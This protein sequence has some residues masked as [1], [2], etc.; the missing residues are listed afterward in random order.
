[1][2]YTIFTCHLESKHYIGNECLIISGDDET[3]C[4]E[5]L[6]TEI[7]KWYDYYEIEQY[8][9][10]IP[11]ENLKEIDDDIRTKIIDEIKENSYYNITDQDLLE[12][13]E[14]LAE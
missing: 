7:S 11:E 6:E 13:L 9:G 10:E 1:M 3:D 2:V 14:N 5:K 12:E 8:S 4:F